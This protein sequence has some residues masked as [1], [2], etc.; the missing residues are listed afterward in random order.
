M[1]KDAYTT[2]FG[3]SLLHVVAFVLLLLPL[4]PELAVSP[5]L[6]G[7]ALVVAGS[8]VVLPRIQMLQIKPYLSLESIEENRLKHKETTTRRKH[9]DR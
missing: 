6:P 2:G 9:K 7:L 5:L 4:L 3:R 1:A 8:I